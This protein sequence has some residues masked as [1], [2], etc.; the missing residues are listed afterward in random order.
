[1]IVLHGDLASRSDSYQYQFAERAHRALANVV[2]IALLR[3]G[4][5]D[6]QG[7]RS[8]GQHGFATGDNHT[9]EVI[10]A[11]RAA[12]RDA[13]S[14]YHGRDIVIVGHSGGAALAADLV[15]GD[16]ALAS[17]LLLVSCPCDLEAWRR[18]MA[19][20]QGDPIWRRP[21]RSVSPLDGVTHF[22][23]PLRI[24]LVTGQDDPVAPPALTGAFA[25]AARASGVDV[26]TVLLARAGH[27][28]LLDPR[29]LTALAD[30]LEAPR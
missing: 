24:R 6:D 1:V 11:L 16:P 22:S 7:A 9:P 30:L 15:E 26:R 3:P 12:V 10:A 27:N 21:V 29:V 25:D 19:D 13:R 8:P 17:D 28:I 4:Y 18:H 14:R 23:P 20:T 2:V 5:E